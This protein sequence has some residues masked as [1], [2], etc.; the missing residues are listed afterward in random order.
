M[1]PA[2]PAGFPEGAER[3]K[4]SSTSRKSECGET[5]FFEEGFEFG[6]A[7]ERKEP[8]IRCGGDE[9]S[10]EDIRELGVGESGNGELLV[11]VGDETVQGRLKSVY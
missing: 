7:G 1:R 6:D 2:F 5:G 3:T 8:A 4:S 11:A 9:L 10:A